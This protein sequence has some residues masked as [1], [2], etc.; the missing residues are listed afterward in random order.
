LTADRFGDDLAM[1]STRRLT[2][3]I[4]LDAAERLNDL[5]L[6]ER[7]DPREQ[8]AI[9]LERVLVRRRPNAADRTGPDGALASRRSPLARSPA[10]Q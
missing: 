9:L 1:E 5:A 2:I 4:G 6:A 7:R 10:V 3:A 8:A